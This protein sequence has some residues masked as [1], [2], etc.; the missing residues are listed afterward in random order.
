MELLAVQEADRVALEERPSRAVMATPAP[1]EDRTPLAAVSV[2]VVV[3]EPA[4]LRRIEL[5][6]MAVAAG[7]PAEAVA[8]VVAGSRAAQR[9]TRETAAMAAR[10][11]AMLRHTRVDLK[12]V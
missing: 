6:V 8:V 1:L 3:E 9:A 11:S 5:P 12:H 4:H 7:N 2:E 10:A